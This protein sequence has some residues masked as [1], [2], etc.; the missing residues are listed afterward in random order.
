MGT[1]AATGCEPRGQG[2]T[3]GGPSSVLSVEYYG[4][5]ENIEGS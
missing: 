5:A 4:P 2:Y 1:Y 3:V